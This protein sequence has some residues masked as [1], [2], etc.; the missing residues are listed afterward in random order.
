MA[1]VSRTAGR[2][3]PRA[4]AAGIRDRF[5]HIHEGVFLR[6]QNGC[7][8]ASRSLRGV[9]KCVLEGSHRA[10][11]VAWLLVGGRTTAGVVFAKDVLVT[12]RILHYLVDRMTCHIVPTWMQKDGFALTDV[13]CAHGETPPEQSPGPVWRRQSPPGNDLHSMKMIKFPDDRPVPGAEVR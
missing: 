9:H 10:K 7:R 6:R 8:A 4:V 2:F 11:G 1:S 3:P 13:Q 5:E 12:R